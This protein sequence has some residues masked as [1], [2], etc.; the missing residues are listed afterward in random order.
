MVDTRVEARAADNDVVLDV[1]LEQVRLFDVGKGFDL[2]VHVE[3]DVVVVAREVGLEGRRREVVEHFGQVPPFFP[4]VLL[5][6]DRR[7]LLDRYLQGVVEF[8]GVLDLLV[9]LG[10]IRLSYSGILLCT[11]P[12]WYKQWSFIGRFDKLF[13]QRNR[14]K[15]LKIISY[16]RIKSL[17]FLQC[18]CPER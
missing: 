10:E 4:R 8:F 3:V 13:L 12:F 11:P 5:A 7:L 16:S 17:R 9:K 1:L 15:R 2:V 14:Q 6:F 18:L